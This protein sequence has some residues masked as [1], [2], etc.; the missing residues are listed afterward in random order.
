MRI[1]LTSEEVMFLKEALSGEISELGMEIADTDQKDFRDHLKRRKAILM[2]L[3]DRI[4]KA[5]VAA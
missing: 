4:E 5:A 3:L 2:N 1:E